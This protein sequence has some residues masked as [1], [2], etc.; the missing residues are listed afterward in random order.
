MRPRVTGIEFGFSMTGDNV[1][2]RLIDAD[3]HTLF[4]PKMP[5]RGHLNGR[6]N[7]AE[8]SFPG[9]FAFLVKLI[10]EFNDGVP[11]IL[12]FFFFLLDC[13]VSIL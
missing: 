10:H 2:G 3:E 6:G 12:L 13:H 7:P 8:D 11:G 4:D 1:A 9:D 5:L